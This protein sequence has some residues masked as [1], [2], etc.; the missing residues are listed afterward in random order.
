[1]DPLHQF[2]VETI[3]P[4]AI[5]GVDISFSNSALWMLLAVAAV[6][7]IMELGLRGAR[8][9]PG[10]LQSLIEA[11]YSFVVKTAKDNA[12]PQGRPF[13]PFILTL[14]TFILAGNLLGILPGSFTFTSHLVVTMALAMLVFVVTTAI[15]FARHGMAY[16]G[17]F[18]PP[19]APKWMAP[20]LIPIEIMS[21]VARPIGLAVR[22]FANMMAGH[23]MLKVFAG[24]S[25]MA[26]EAVGLA[27][28]LALAIGPVA[29]NVALTGFEALVAVL[30]AYVFMVLTCLYLRDALEMHH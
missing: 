29:V 30:Q 27:G 14:F 11:L 13:V 12:G 2:T 5:G 28:G 25:V 4:L 23:T 3:V 16:F 18:F 8:L 1:M 20:V 15:G 24:F 7:G 10:R 6:F 21:F 26:I 22:L 9:V 17:I 19:G